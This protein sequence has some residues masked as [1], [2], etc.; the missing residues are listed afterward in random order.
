MLLLALLSFSLVVST[1]GQY[2]VI[3]LSYCL[4]PLMSR[5]LVEG[6]LAT[7]DARIAVGL[8]HLGRFSLGTGAACCQK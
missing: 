7:S 6:A 1:A 2:G 8:V 5:G 4:L 3:S